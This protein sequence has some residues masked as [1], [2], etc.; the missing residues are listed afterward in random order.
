Y[1]CFIPIIWIA[2]RQGIQRVVSA[3]LV[4]DFGIVATMHFLPPPPG[5]FIKIALLMLVVSS[6]GLLVGSEVSERHRL[7]M[8]LSQQT[9][10]LDSLIQ[11]TPLGIVVLD[12]EK[13][14]E[15]INLACEKLFQYE[16]HELASVILSNTETTSTKTT[17]S[18]QLIV[19]VFAGKALH[20]T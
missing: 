2:M 1:I 20:K 18:T 16:P 13:R 9:M 10:Y 14:V 8:D 19:E 3:V 17:D 6:V 11:N 12:R 4:L 5:L 7:A 15:L